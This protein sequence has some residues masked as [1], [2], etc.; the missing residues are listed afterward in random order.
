MPARAENR[1]ARVVADLPLS[2]SFFCWSA[3]SFVVV[4]ALPARTFSASA[5]SA[6]A[7]AC[8]FSALTEVASAFAEFAAARFHASSEPAA[9]SS[10]APVPAA[11]SPTFLIFRAAVIR[12]RG[13]DRDGDGLASHQPPL[14]S[15]M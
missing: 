9:K 10:L 3:N 6:V 8:A 11:A 13:E 7:L 15:S 4:V 12:A 1:D 2:S 14:R 5:S